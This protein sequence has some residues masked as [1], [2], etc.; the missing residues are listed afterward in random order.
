MTIEEELISLRNKIDNVLEELSKKAKQ[1]EL[2]VSTSVKSDNELCRPKT[3][4][5]T[6]LS[7]LKLCPRSFNALTNNRG[8]GISTVEELC[9]LT[10]EEVMK[11]RNLGKTSLID[12]QKKLSSIGR[13]LNM[14]LPPQKN[15]T[16]RKYL[17]LD[18]L[19]S[20]EDYEEVRCQRF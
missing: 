8:E 12:I 5:G 13:S 2:S 4:V 18:K 6:S 9:L 15:S 16:P 3:L 17:Y 10:P 19:I 20:K 7:C 11:F 1:T 14:S